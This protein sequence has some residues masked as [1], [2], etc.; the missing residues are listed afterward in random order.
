MFEDLSYEDSTTSIY[1]G[2]G[3]DT[4]DLAIRNRILPPDKRNPKLT[5]IYDNILYIAKN[6]KDLYL[7][8]TKLVKECPR[9]SNVCDGSQASA[10]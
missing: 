8:V 3:F 6:T 4:I 1:R 5:K 2:I 10:F 7:K 9:D